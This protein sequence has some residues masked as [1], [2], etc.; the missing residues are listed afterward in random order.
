[1][2]NVTG[3]YPRGQLRVSDSD[4]DRAVAE[5]SEHYQA[6]RLTL[7][8]FEDRSGRALQARTG[9]ELGGLFTDLPK[10]AVPEAA[11]PGAA[12]PG[13]GV[14]AAG[15][16]A[17]LAGPRPLP[18]AR[19]AVLCV[20]AVLVIGGVLG[21]LQHGYHASFGL[22]IPVIVLAVVARHRRCGR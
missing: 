14:P 8:E 21:G 22:L 6:G 15:A 4:R 11:V 2:D 1:M 10:A 17:G 3:G 16:G 18:A 5:L 12:V 7:E 19:I 13:A 9:G 20:V